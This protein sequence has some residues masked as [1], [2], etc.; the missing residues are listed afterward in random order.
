TTGAGATHRARFLVAATG[1]LSVP[2]IPD[3]RGRDDFRGEAYHTGRW[4]ATP[5]DFA[6]KRVAVVG[7]GS[8]GVQIVPVLVPEVAELVVYHRRPTCCPPL[9]TARTTPDEQARL[10]AGFA[11]MREI[12]NTSVAGFLHEPHDRATFDDSR[13]ERWAFYEKMWTSP[14]F[15]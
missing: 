5:V 11:E 9:N 10:R 4:P 13:D 8:S 6:G 1:V 3:V 14:G 12:L 15:S 2:F 7:T